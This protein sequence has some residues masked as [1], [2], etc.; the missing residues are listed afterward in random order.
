MNSALLPL[1]AILHLR[2][3]SKWNTKGAYLSLK[4]YDFYVNIVSKFRFNPIKSLLRL[5]KTS[6]LH[7]LSLTF[8]KDCFTFE[9]K[10]QASQQISA[11][12]LNPDLI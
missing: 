6:V 9:K 7:E 8:F 5:Y 10:F 4:K 2:K 1:R 11:F 3:N 12:L